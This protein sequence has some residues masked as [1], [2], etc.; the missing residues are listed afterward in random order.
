MLF[1]VCWSGGGWLLYVATRYGITRDPK[2]LVASTSHRIE[3]A[4]ELGKRPVDHGPYERLARLP[5]NEQFSV[6]VTQKTLQLDRLPIELEGLTIWHLSDWH[7]SGTLRRE[8]FERVV[9]ELRRKPADMICF[10]GDLID[11]L[12]CT[13]WFPET[14]GK[15]Q[16]EHGMFY[17][18]GNHDWHRDPDTIRA[19]LTQL[20]WRDVASQVVLPTIRGRQF[21]LGGDE[22]PWMGTAPNFATLDA[23]L[24][25]LLLSHTPDNI[26]RAQS[27]RID[28]MLSGH[29][30]GGQVQL[31]L[32]GPVYSPSLYG[33][34][35]SSG[36]F[37]QVPTLL[38][39]SRGLAGLHPLR[40]R[41]APE[42]TRLTLRRT[43]TSERQE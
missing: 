4:L 38:H 25:R 31:P 14:L 35:F 7:F 29:T 33:C 6:A 16:A 15:L 18:L 42:V 27:Q 10:T 37:Y 20:G 43:S 2:Q 8:Y 13:T 9:L 19:Q 28:L 17:I 41:C 36:T 21:A 3:I 34:K 12:N 22:T 23:N 32:I 30:H 26:R 5:F 39:V 24:F 11:N 40:W 1:V